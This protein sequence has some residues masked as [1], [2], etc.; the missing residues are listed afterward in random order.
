MLVKWSGNSVNLDS[1]KLVPS[2]AGNKT[3]SPVMQR[4]SKQLVFP[5]LS[6]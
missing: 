3:Q 4:I 6:Y 1:V 2:W 5:P